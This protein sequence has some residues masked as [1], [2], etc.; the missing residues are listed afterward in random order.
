MVKKCSWCSGGTSCLSVCVDF[1]WFYHWAPLKSTWLFAFSLQVFTYI[2]LSLNLLF[3][4]LTLPFLAHCWLMVNSV[5]TRHC[6]YL[7][8]WL[9][10]ISWVFFPVQK[11]AARFTGAEI[12][13]T[14]MEL[15]NLKVW[16]TNVQKIQT[17][18]IAKWPLENLWWEYKTL[19]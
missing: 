5:S 1:L 19:H 8:F 9:Q 6:N 14:V 3:S 2:N 7:F 4:K 16:M 12:E 17:Q 13:G 18:L 10:E 15:L 11:G